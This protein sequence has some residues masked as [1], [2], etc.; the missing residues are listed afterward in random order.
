MIV[1][2]YTSPKTTKSVHLLVNKYVWV[3]CNPGLSNCDISPWGTNSDHV[4]PV[5]N[6]SDW[7]FSIV[8]PSIKTRSSDL[9]W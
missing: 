9:M 7:F 6:Y 4:T 5:D 1:L 2:I 3:L 8:S